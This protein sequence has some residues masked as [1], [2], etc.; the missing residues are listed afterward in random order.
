MDA[1]L[2]TTI[3]D[4]DALK[5]IFA[6]RRTEQPWFYSSGALGEGDNFEIPEFP[7]VVYNELP[8]SPFQEVSETSN[9]EMRIYTFYVYDE[10]GDYG[11]IN[12]ILREIRR[13]V[14]GM[15]PFTVVEDGTTFRCSYS[16][17]DGVSQRITDPDQHS[18]VRFGTARFTVSN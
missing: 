11:R 7:Y 15:V 4:D 18:G 10:L 2:F 8:S 6:V 1:H 5:A 3:N 17:W 9:A 16:R 14:K 13:I 12:L